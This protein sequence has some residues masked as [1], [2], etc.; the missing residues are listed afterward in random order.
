MN[1]LTRFDVTTDVEVRGF[2]LTKD[3]EYDAIGNMISQTGIGTYRYTDSR[4]GPH[5]VDHAGDRVYGYDAVG[6]MTNRNGDSITYNPLNK[7][8][9]LANH[10]NNKTVTF[11]YGVG[12][13]RYQKQT[14]DGKYTFYIGKAYEEQVEDNTEKQI[15]YISLGG[16]TIGTHT[17]VKDTN[18][19]TTNPNY[20]EATFNR[21]F[22][23][24]ALGSITAIT[25]DT[26]TVV[27]RRSYEPF[28][29]IR[30]MDYGTNNNTIANT[31]LQ[32]TRAFTG[33][34]QIAELSGLVHMN[35]RVYDSDIG[36][37]LSADTMIQD[38]HDSQSY[39]RYSYVRNNPLKYT[40][41]TGNS[42]WTKFRDKWLKPIVS[43]VI[44]VV[45]IAA[46]MGYGALATTW[47]GGLNAVQAGA[48]VGGIS[49]GIMT[50]SLTGAVKGAVFGAISAGIANGIGNI[51]EGMASSLGASAAKAGK[52]LLHGLSRAAI[53]RAQG[54]KFS[55]GFWSGFAGS[56]LGGLS[57]QADTLGGQLVIQAVVGGTASEL[58]GGKF[59]NG[60]VSA[61]FVMMF[62]DW[63]HD[64]SNLVA[65]FGDTVS[66]GLTSAFRQ[67]YGYDSVIDYD[68]GLYLGGEVAG[69]A[70]S[71][72]AIWTAGLYGGAN[73]VF[74]SGQGNMARAMSLGTSLEATPIGRILNFGGNKI[75]YWI[76]K[77]ASSTFASNASGTALKVGTFEG[78]IWRT[79]EK[80]ILQRNGIGINIVP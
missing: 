12:G 48:L 38:P 25:D 3:Y 18:Y 64:A 32:T 24:D 67:T 9:T 52:A 58:G 69:Y 79:I 44:S 46:T 36:R 41:P 10:T 78:N 14:S 30:A 72:P 68:S 29:K 16:K 7:P 15:C 51:G 4:Y 17:E 49:G 1:R 8:A 70:A 50:G 43:I 21:Y 75:P 20:N 71:I 33:H 39:N 56:A 31:T 40:D 74:W 73:S 65:G 62:N 37:F 54:G 19:V 27:E 63:L 76:W 77:R 26:G 34:E 59:A 2:A 6:N 80:P 55:A 53:T 47:V 23:T 28:G 22:H 42:W 35:A 5:A 66:F 57:A 60:A 11:T 13:A 45:I 61:A